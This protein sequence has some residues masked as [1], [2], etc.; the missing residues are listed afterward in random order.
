[1]VKQA[2]FSPA[3]SRVNPNV[4]T[5]GIFTLL[6][7]ITIMPKGLGHLICAF[8]GA[9]IYLA[10]LMLNPNV[11]R[12]QS[13]KIQAANASDPNTHTPKSD[14]GQGPPKPELKSK[15]VTT[16]EIPEHEAVHA[17]DRASDEMS[18]AEEDSSDDESID[19]ESTD[20]DSD[21]GI[22]ISAKPM[23]CTSQQVSTNGNPIESQHNNQPPQQLL[24]Q[25]E[26]L[27]QSQQEL[28]HFLKI[29]QETMKLTSKIA[30]EA[31]K[32]RAE[33]ARTETV[34]LEMKSTTKN[35]TSL[36]MPITEENLIGDTNGMMY[37]ESPMI[38][39]F[40]SQA[41]GMDVI[42]FM[43]PICMSDC[44]L[45]TA[46]STE[47]LQPAPSTDCWNWIEKGWCPRGAA[48]RW[49]HPREKDD[50]NIFWPN[51]QSTGG[52][53]FGEACS[54]QYDANVGDSKATNVDVGCMDN[55]K[56]NRACEPDDDDYMTDDGF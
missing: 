15:A 51:M 33:A 54:E 31:A 40:C 25:K 26:D 7:F 38:D 16:M 13:T 50:C 4:S 29:Q 35:V 36:R 28:E 19:E 45:S 37:A 22:P 24:K 18:N 9:G 34:A 55:F 20:E 56:N 10:F 39:P 48:C 23:N 8:L 47:I 46:T 1:M 6:A 44:L 49:A 14:C 27:K 11:D 30:I 41:C 12:M 3:Q 2:F 52:T 17:D 53:K 5:L 43:Q 42:P 21:G 32:V